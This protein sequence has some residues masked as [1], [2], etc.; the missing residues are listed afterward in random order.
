MV[1]RREGE[2]VVTAGKVFQASQIL[3]S[4]SDSR[5]DNILRVSGDLAGRYEC[6]VGNE[7]GQQ[8]TSLTVR[9]EMCV[10]NLLVRN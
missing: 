9:G 4:A 7:K 2:E 8:K 1:W 10:L 6:E 5:Y 3:V